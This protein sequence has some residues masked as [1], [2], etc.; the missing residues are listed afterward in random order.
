LEEPVSGFTELI[1]R[2]RAETVTFQPST[3]EDNIRMG[4][5]GDFAGDLWNE[6]L[7][8]RVVGKILMLR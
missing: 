2:F 4:D 8:D 3:Q 7:C 5:V 1:L 6:Y